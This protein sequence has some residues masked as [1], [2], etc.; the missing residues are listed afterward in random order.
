MKEIKQN[1]TE[2]KQYELQPFD[3]K[4]VIEITEEQLPLSCPLPNQ[5]LWNAHPRVYLPILESGEFF[6]PYCNAHYILK[7]FRD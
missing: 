6:C 3:N 4:G 5:T 2:F 7:G 1:K